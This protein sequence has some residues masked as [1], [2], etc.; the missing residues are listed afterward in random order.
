MKHLKH[1]TC[2][3]CRMPPTSDVLP[4]CQAAFEAYVVAHPSAKHQTVTVPQ[5]AAWFA[6]HAFVPKPGIDACWACGV[7]RDGH[8]KASSEDRSRA[9]RIVEWVE[10]AQQKPSTSPLDQAILTVYADMF[11]TPPHAVDQETW[12]AF[13]SAVRRK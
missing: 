6:V 12:I 2:L 1:C 9:R 10:R 7:S 8:V 3:V 13:G 5:L 4:L 11:P